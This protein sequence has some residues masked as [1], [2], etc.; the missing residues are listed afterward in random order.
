MSKEQVGESQEVG[1]PSPFI[2][3][4]HRVDQL[5]SSLLALGLWLP[6]AIWWLNSDLLRYP[7]MVAYYYPVGEFSVYV[8]Q[9]II[10][11]PLLPL[12]A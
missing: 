3:A 12:Q 7:L 9:R 2:I 8:T 4:H 5:H 1:S 6:V 10:V 11:I